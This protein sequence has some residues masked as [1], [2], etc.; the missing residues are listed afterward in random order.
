MRLISL[1][2]A[3]EIFRP[4]PPQF[5]D[6]NWLTDSSILYF[7]CPSFCPN[8]LKFVTGWNCFLVISNILIKLIKV[9][10]ERFHIL[11]VPTAKEPSN[12]NVTLE[13]RNK[14]VVEGQSVV[15]DMTLRREPNIFKTRYMIRVYDVFTCAVSFHK[16]RNS[17]CENVNVLCIC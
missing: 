11:F 4:P 17:L 12:I 6:F 2:I 10:H 3:R 13:T 9:T 14:S 1:V 8:Y 16:R 7:V 5:A 15:I